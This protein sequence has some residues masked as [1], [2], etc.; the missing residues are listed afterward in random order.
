[1]CVFRQ[2]KTLH[3]FSR[4]EITDSN[5]KITAITVNYC[6]FDSNPSHLCQ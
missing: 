4:D 1:M 5:N 6:N 3:P 2:P